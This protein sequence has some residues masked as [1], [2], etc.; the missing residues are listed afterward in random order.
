MPLVRISLREGKTGEYKKAIADGIHQ[1]MVERLT[2]RCR[3]DFKLSLS[4][5]PAI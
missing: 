5:R 4:T 3:I 1:A 2:R